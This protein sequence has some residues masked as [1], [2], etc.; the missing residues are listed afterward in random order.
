MCS[1]SICRKKAVDSGTLQG[2]ITCCT[3]YTRW[4]KK[5]AQDEESQNG[6][7]Y[8]NPLFTEGQKPSNPKNDTNLTTE[9][10]GKDGTGDDTRSLEAGAEQAKIT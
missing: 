7:M 10:E 8:E 9:H 4:Q 6:K 3:Y 5:K 2:C 1:K